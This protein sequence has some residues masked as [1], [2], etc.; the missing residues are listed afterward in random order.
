MSRRILDFDN[1]VAEAATDHVIDAIVTALKSKND[2]LI[3]D[4]IEGA[5]GMLAY[6]DILL[7]C[8]YQDGLTEIVS[9]LD[10][11][12]ADEGKRVRLYEGD[13]QVYPVEG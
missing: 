12:A 4:A 7:A 9:T 13:K 2:G 1:M 10:L 8:I 3:Y 11:I 6:R 5:M